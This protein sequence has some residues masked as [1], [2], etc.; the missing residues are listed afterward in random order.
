MKFFEN[1]GHSLLDFAYVYSEQQ[2]AMQKEYLDDDEEQKESTLLSK[3]DE[4][5][6]VKIVKICII[7]ANN[8][9]RNI[10]DI[11][12]KMALQKIEMSQPKETLNMLR[13]YKSDHI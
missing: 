2:V 13:A 11:L 4:N 5:D 12:S 8:C 6:K 1:E 3:S 10:I 9:Y 7:A